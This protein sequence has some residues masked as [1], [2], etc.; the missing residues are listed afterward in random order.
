M[1]V[2]EQASKEK[3]IEERERE[4]PEKE[5]NKEKRDKEQR[6]EKGIAKEPGVRVL[7]PTCPHSIANHWNCKPLIIPPLDMGLC[8]VVWEAS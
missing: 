1:C 7:Q 2:C 6:G 4:E 3:E 8:V 5:R